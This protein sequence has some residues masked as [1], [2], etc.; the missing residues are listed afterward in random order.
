MTNAVR[1]LTSKTFPG[2]GKAFSGIT[3]SSAQ[4]GF[5]GSTAAKANSAATN[6]ATGA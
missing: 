3:V 2:R 5:N 1:P 6:T 4:A